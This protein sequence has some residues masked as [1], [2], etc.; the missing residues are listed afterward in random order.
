[1]ELTLEEVNKLNKLN[2][3]LASELAAKNPVYTPFQHGNF[4]C[5]MIKEVLY[6]RRGEEDV[7]LCFH[8]E[9]TG[10][11]CISAQCIC[12]YTVE[13]VF[14]LSSWLLVQTLVHF[15]QNC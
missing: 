4:T 7:F 15:S 10:R 5:I 6:G 8:T 9:V 2:M 14:T 11:A 3:E 13:N 12:A 1:M